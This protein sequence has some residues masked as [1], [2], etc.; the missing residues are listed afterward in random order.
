[1]IVHTIIVHKQRIPAAEVAKKNKHQR[2][3]FQ[4]KKGSEEHKFFIFKRALTNNPFEKWD[5]VVYRG[6]SYLINDIY[7]ESMYRF[8]EWNGLAPLILEIMELDSGEIKC[9]NPGNVRKI[10]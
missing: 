6:K 10:S 5:T 7:D 3:Q 1:M 2:E 4:G 8:V 9:V